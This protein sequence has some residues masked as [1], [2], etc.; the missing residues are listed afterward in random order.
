MRRL[1]APWGRRRF[2]S[3][4]GAAQHPSGRCQAHARGREWAGYPHRCGTVH[5]CAHAR[6]WGRGTL[7]F[8][9]VVLVVFAPQMMEMSSPEGRVGPCKRE[10]SSSSSALVASGALRAARRGARGGVRGDTGRW[11]SALRGKRGGLI[12]SKGSRPF[13]GIL[14]AL[15]G[16]LAVLR[17]HD[18]TFGSR[19]QPPRAA[20]LRTNIYIYICM[21]LYIYI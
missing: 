13:L 14:C 3:Q 2:G 9:F 5:T 17:H 20:M 12:S 6:R 15:S 4:G 11:W 1:A 10:G 21:R 18:T 8:Y 16:T 7:C 19:K